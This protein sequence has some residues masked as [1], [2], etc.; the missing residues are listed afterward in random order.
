MYI[1]RLKTKNLG[2]LKSGRAGLDGLP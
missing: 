2:I 1:D